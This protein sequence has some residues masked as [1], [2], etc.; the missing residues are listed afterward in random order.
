MQLQHGELQLR[1]PGQRA[2]GL[3]HLDNRDDVNFPLSKNILKFRL[4]LNDI[5]SMTNY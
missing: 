1:R 4:D 5:F 3:V 2:G